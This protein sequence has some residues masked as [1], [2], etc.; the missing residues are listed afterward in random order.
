MY[1]SVFISKLW[2]KSMSTVWVANAAGHPYHKVLSL[3]PDAEIKSLTM[4]DVN[5]LEID[6]LMWHLARGIGK[7]VQA[8]DYLLISG[9]PMVNAAAFTLWLL[10]FGRCNLVQWNAVK[11]AYELKNVE[12]ENLGRILEQHMSV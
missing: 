12:R 5:P 4:D 7:Y 6:R 9:T 1:G 3:V 11:R 2:E 8:D 10:H